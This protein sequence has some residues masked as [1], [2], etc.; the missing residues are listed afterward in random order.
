[1]FIAQADDQCMISEAGLKTVIN[2]CAAFYRKLVI[3]DTAAL[4][5]SKLCAIFMREPRWLKSRIIELAVRDTAEGIKEVFEQNKTKWYSCIEDEDYVRS[6]SSLRTIPLSFS[7]LAENFVNKIEVALKDHRGLAR[8]GLSPEIVEKLTCALVEE[9][10]EKKIVTRST[11]FTLA[12]QEPNHR[13][14]LQTFWKYHYWNNVPA[15]LSVANSAYRMPNSPEDVFCSELQEFMAAAVAEEIDQLTF[16]ILPAFRDL[17]YDEILDIRLLRSFKKLNDLLVSQT[18]SG[19]EL[20]AAFVEHAR[21]LSGYVIKRGNLGDSMKMMH[22]IVLY[23]RKKVPSG[24][25]WKLK[26]VT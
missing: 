15:V 25:W 1:M 20:W 16:P 5:N 13:I 24:R 6:L 17:S 23:L 4:C 3:A 18:P 10:K 21:S 14:A 12:D 7:D 26:W 2:L 9:Y 11:I 8:L 22:K 19:S